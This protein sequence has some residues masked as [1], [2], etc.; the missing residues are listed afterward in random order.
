MNFVM[1]RPKAK[2]LGYLEA[3]AN[4]AAAA[5]ATTDAAAMA[6]ATATK[7][8]NA[9]APVLQLQ[10]AATAADL[11]WLAV[12]EPAEDLGEIG[13]FAVHENADAVDAAGDPKDGEDCEAHEHEGQADLPGW[14]RG[15]GDAEVH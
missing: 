8:A 15:E 1:L 12:F 5:N 7:T 2:A 6:A 4:A 14:D 3:T 11:M 9:T 13:L 10:R